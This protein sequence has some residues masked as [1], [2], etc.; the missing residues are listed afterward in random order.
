MLEQRE[1]V[2]AGFEGE[3]GEG[4]G[5]VRFEDGSDHFDRGAGFVHIALGV[6]VVFDR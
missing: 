5:A 3:S 6:A 2:L 1:R 4:A